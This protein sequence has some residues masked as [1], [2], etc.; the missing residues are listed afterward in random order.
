M[1]EGISEVIVFAVG[2]AV[3]LMAIIA[4]TLMLF[5]ARARVN[6]PVFLLGWMIA[7][8]A[9]SGL[10]FLAAKQG[11]VSTDSSASDTVAWGKFVFGV[12]LLLLAARGWKNRPAAGVAPE[13][14]KWMSGVDALSPAKAFALGLL[15][16][17]V[18]P[19]NLMLSLAAGAG[20]AELGLSSTDSLVSLLVFVIVGSCSIAA[21]VI[22]YLVGGTDA[23][24]RLREIKDWLIVNNPAVTAVVFL[25]LGV[26][27]IAKSLQA[28]S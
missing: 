2:V 16:A 19:K 10:A 24:T 21:P 15:L 23:E 9:V 8:A 18:N 3:S 13:M 26:D 28:A 7:L 22:Y 12:L 6:G 14:P 27:L 1:I 20:L 4:V 17:G 11:S 5:S 25:I